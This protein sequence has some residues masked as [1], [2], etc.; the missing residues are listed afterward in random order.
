MS[1][2]DD[3][4]EMNDLKRYIDDVRMIKRTL[5]VAD[6]SFHIFSWFY[7]VLA[8]LALVG[9][10]INV[11]LVHTAGIAEHDSLVFVWI[12]I[13]VLAAGTE[14]VAWILKSSQEKLPVLTPAFTRY[15]VAGG[16]MVVGLVTI[17]IV[18]IRQGLLLPGVVLLLVGT[19]MSIT[20]Q[21]VHFWFLLESF[22][23]VVLGLF[24]ELIGARGEAY[25]VVAGVI[26][27][28]AMVLAGVIEGIL[29][30]QYRRG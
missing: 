19:I 2:G 13:F 27:A 21:Y 24:F 17:A 3:K 1:E 15:L 18:L 9:T 30:R 4:I 28:G 14:M 12:P 20:V 22:G 6:G 25:F 26:I 16:T 5:D 23:L 8:G 29:S 7:Y 11:V 10:G